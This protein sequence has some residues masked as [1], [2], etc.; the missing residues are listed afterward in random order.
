MGFGR[1]KLLQKSNLNNEKL[2]TGKYTYGKPGQT[3]KNAMH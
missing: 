2:T 3:K 1:K